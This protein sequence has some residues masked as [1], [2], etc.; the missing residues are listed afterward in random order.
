MAHKAREDETYRIQNEARVVSGP[1]LTDLA[2]DGRLA[3]T[4]VL[5][6]SDYGGVAQAVAA[7]TL[8]P[9]PETVRQTGNRA[10]F[11]A[12]RC[13]S[14]NERRRF[15]ER[16]G[17][18][19]WLDDNALPIA[20]FDWSQRMPRR[21]RDLQ[22]NHLYARSDDPDCFTALPNLCRTPSFL[23]KLSD[24]DDTAQA[25]LRRRSYELYGW[26]PAGE[27]IPVKPPSY[28]ELVWAPPLPPVS[29]LEHVMR[30]AIARRRRD[31][32]R[33]A[34][35]AGWLFSGGEPDPAYRA[36]PR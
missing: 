34:A 5:E 31:C 21:L 33:I 8:F 27:P 35:E 19:L 26:R 17:K 1:T 25:L 29:D 15:E 32:L 23:A 10:I 3:L 14:N 7:L 16:D 36:K 11:P 2:F 12:V 20:V 9:H 30:K 24:H 13:R 18:R 22:L 28:D 4:R 6:Q